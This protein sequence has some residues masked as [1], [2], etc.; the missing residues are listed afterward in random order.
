MIID[1]EFCGFD[2]SSRRLTVFL[3]KAFGNPGYQVRLRSWEEGGGVEVRQGRVW[4]RNDEAF[5]YPVSSA[6][7]GDLDTQHPFRPSMKT[8]PEDAHE[9]SGVRPHHCRL[10][11]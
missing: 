11:M 3:G 1:K 10:L 9:L 7:S 4:Q 8:L 6:A 2:A 5:D